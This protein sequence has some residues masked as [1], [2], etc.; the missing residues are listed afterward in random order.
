MLQF[1]HKLLQHHQ[2]Q[3]QQLFQ[4][5]NKF[6][7]NKPHNNVHPYKEDLFSLSTNSLKSLN[8]MQPNNIHNTQPLSSNSLN[9]LSRPQAPFSY[10]IHQQH[11]FQPSYVVNESNGSSKSNSQT[12][13]NSSHKSDNLAQKLQQ[14]TKLSNGNNLLPVSTQEFQQQLRMSKDLD[15]MN[16]NKNLN[17]LKCGENLNYLNKYNQNDQQFIEKAKHSDQE[18]DD[19]E[20]G[21][22]DEDEDENNDKS[23]C[24]NVFGTALKDL[25]QNKNWQQSIIVNSSN[26]STFIE[27]IKMSAPLKNKNL[28]SPRGFQP[29]T[30]SDS[31]STSVYLSDTSQLPKFNYVSLLLDEYCDKNTSINTEALAYKYLKQNTNTNSDSCKSQISTCNYESFNIENI[32]YPSSNSNTFLL[33]TQS[34]SSSLG[35]KQQ[36]FQFYQNSFQINDSSKPSEIKSN[37]TSNQM[38]SKDNPNQRLNLNHQKNA[39]LLPSQILSVKPKDSLNKIKINEMKEASSSGESEKSEEELSSDEDGEVW[40]FGKPKSGPLAHNKFLDKPDTRSI[41]NQKNKNF[42][43]NVKKSVPLPP[44]PS[45]LQQSVKQKQRKKLQIQPKRNSTGAMTDAN[46]KQKDFSDQDEEI[47]RDV[48]TVLDIEKLKRLPKLL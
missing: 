35:V 16:E 2:N 44:L 24:E 43:Q 4:P 40:L 38:L 6:S 30:G 9:D 8:H 10:Q 20:D 46:G 39:D 48:T 22:G 12:S 21:E 14:V 45:S 29:Q 28:L 3:H 13:L 32:C 23:E 19:E 15:E 18:D 41:E 47:D 5:N 1:Q 33:E 42:H 25:K 7:A 26:Q 37:S 31:A 17:K 11:N 36:Q 34:S 27:N